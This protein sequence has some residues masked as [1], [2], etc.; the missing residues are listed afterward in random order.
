MCV[1]VRVCTCVCSYI[2]LRDLFTPIYIIH[3]IYPLYWWSMLWNFVPIFRVTIFIWSLLFSFST[4]LLSIETI[5]MK[6]ESHVMTKINIQAYRY[7][8][9]INDKNEAMNLEEKNRELMWEFGGRRRKW[10]IYTVFPKDK[11]LKNTTINYDTKKIQ[12]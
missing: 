2:E 3:S 8:T 9:I 11:S 6:L 7:V 10:C 12:W 4:I 5:L 1:Y